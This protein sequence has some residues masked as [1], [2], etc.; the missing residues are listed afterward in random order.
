MNALTSTGLFFGLLLGVRHAIEPDHLTAVA[1]MLTETRSVRRTLVLG[2]AWGI[3]HATSILAVALALGA[4]RTE[5]PRVLADVFELLVALMLLFL[6]ARALARAFL[7]REDPADCH[8]T[9]P[10]IHVGRWKFA[11]RSLLMGLIHGLAGSGILTAMVSAQFD[12]PAARVAFV[13][14]FGVGAAIGMTVLSGILGCP[15]ARLGSAPRLSRAIAGCAGL[16]SLVM[17]V[18]WGGPTA[19]RMLGG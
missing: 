13:L 18:W 6:G 15:M 9:T 19:W 7:G 5:L 16:L 1:T 8:E 12:A 4:L 14:L 2:L 17:G 10:H 3:G 11:R